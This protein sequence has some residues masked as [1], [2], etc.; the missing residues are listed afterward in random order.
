META[1]GLTVYGKKNSDF[2]QLDATGKLIDRWSG[3]K[4][5]RGCRIYRIL[6]HAEIVFSHCE[7]ITNQMERSHDN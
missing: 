5:T 6:H 7:R 4:V 1:Y 3:F 2:K